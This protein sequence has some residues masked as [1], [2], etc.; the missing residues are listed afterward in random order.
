MTNFSDEHGGNCGEVSELVIF[1]NYKV[2]G[3]PLWNATREENNESMNE[4]ELIDA[5]HNISFFNY[6]THFFE[7]VFL[8]DYANAFLLICDDKSIK[9][10]YGLVREFNLTSFW[11][12]N[13]LLIFWDML[14]LILD[15]LRGI[16]FIFDSGNASCSIYNALKHCDNFVELLFPLLFFIKKGRIMQIKTTILIV[17]V[18][19]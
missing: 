6:S 1:K 14:I 13:F 3:N 2:C 11:G 7:D 5:S 19:M 16:K 4:S 15:V 12:D 17:K 10:S 8:L 9:D 18:I